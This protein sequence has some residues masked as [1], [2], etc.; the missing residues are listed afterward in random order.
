M[1]IRGGWNGL[2]YA[3]FFN[4]PELMDNFLQGSNPVP[5]DSAAGEAHCYTPLHT[6]AWQSNSRCVEFLLQHGADKNAKSMMAGEFSMTP[7]QLCIYSS[8]DLSQGSV[9]ETIKILLQHGASIDFRYNGLGVAHHLAQQR[10]SVEALKMILQYR[11]NFIGQLTPNRQTPLHSATGARNKLAVEL[12]LNLGANVHAKNIIGDTA[13]HNAYMSIGPSTRQSSSR[14]NEEYVR[15]L[16][17]D[18]EDAKSVIQLLLHAGA[19]PDAVGLEDIPWDTPEF[20]MYD[21]YEDASEFCISPWQQIG[22]ENATPLPQW[23]FYDWSVYS[24]W[25][26]IRFSLPQLIVSTGPRVILVVLASSKEAKTK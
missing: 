18:E 2:H 13:L 26:G 4:R 6:A 20:R 10:G 3:A 21:E 5:V 11:P 14:Y 9:I 22:S 8:R 7:L 17:G 24:P 15:L 25:L 16:V 23:S 19:D 12:L 1:E